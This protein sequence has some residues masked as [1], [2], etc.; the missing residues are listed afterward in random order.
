MA[1]WND[2]K[3]A[4]EREFNKAENEFISNEQ[5]LLECIANH[6][7]S[8]KGTTSI[9]GYN[10]EEMLEFLQKPASEIREI[11]G[12]NWENLDDTVM[13]PLIYSLTKKVKK[14]ISFLG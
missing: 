9:Q 4:F 6:L 10:T 12:G 13:D 7:A 1:D 3:N 8:L 14:S 11:L 5:T 2:I